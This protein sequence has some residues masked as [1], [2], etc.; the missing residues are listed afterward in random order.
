MRLMKWQ[1][2]RRLQLARGHVLGHA[3]LE[4]R[5]EQADVAVRA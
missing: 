5:G 1:N 3:L 4:D 2:S